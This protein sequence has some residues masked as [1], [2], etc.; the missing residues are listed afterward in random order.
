M[1]KKL[2]AFILFLSIA[3]NF[4]LIALYLSRPEHFRNETELELLEKKIPSSL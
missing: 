4:F 2:F 1:N 3:I